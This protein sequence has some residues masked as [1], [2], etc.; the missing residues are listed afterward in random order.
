MHSSRANPVHL[1]DHLGIERVYACVGGSLGGLQALAAAAQ[2]P[3]RVDRLVSVSA[4]ARS[5]P[6][7]IAL[8]YVQRN[9]VM[10]DPDWY[11]DLCAWGQARCASIS[12]SLPQVQWQL[13]RYKPLPVRRSQARTHGTHLS[14]F[15]VCVCVKCAPI[16]SLYAT[17]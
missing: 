16:A 5:H 2:F 3:D 14:L 9:I 15:C 13:L 4:S 11:A 6:T 7:A 1:Q 17:D 10:S 8:R 12:R